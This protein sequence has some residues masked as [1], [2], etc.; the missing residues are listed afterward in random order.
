MDLYILWLCPIVYTIHIIEEAPRFV[1]W[2][3]RYPKLFTSIFNHKMFILGNTVWMLYNIVCV[4]LAILYPAPW[5]LI[6]GLSTAS[7]IFANSWIHI[8]TT[9]S[10]G[11]YSP[12]VIT[13]S[14]LYLPVSIFIYWYFWQQGALDP[15]IFI[16][17]VIIGFAVM[18]LPFLGTRR[19]ANLKTLPWIVREK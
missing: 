3:R 9:L 5:S 7:W 17:S 15:M 4:L 13:A 2:T 12:G 6:L 8:I 10:S 18:Y 11:I 1:S 16:L 19:I 14:T